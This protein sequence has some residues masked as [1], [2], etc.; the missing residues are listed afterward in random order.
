MANAWMLFVAAINKSKP[1]VDHVAVRASG[2]HVQK[3]F[4]QV[5]SWGRPSN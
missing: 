4:V 3:A 1:M 2:S 5:E